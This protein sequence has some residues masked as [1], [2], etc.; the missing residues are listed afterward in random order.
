VA[1]GSLRLPAARRL[2]DPAEFKRVYD[3]RMPVHTPLLVAF[4]QANGRA[5]ARLGVSV[6][7]QHGG[8]VQRNRIKRVLRA[9]FRAVQA[10]LPGGIDLVLVPRKGLPLERFTAGAVEDALR[11]ALKHLRARAEEA[12]QARE[13]AAEPGARHG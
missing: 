9:G 3:G 5:Q 10:Q 8:A 4:V 7:R 2:H 12:R 13:K 11:G 6:S 1:R